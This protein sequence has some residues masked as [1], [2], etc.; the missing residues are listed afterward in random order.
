MFQ[1]SLVVQNVQFDTQRVGLHR[2][3]LSYSGLQDI[4]PCD[5]VSGPPVSLDMP[6]WNPEMVSL[7]IQNLVCFNNYFIFRFVY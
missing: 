2:L 3:S 5:V 4:V 6:D 7:L 1:P